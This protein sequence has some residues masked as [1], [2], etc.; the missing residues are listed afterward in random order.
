LESANQNI[1]FEVKKQVNADLNNRKDPSGDA[2][3]NLSEHQGKLERYQGALD[4]FIAEQKSFTEQQTTLQSQVDKK[5]KQWEAEN[6]RE[7]KF[8]DGNF[9]CP[10]CKRPL[11]EEGIEQEKEKMITDFKEDKQTSLASINREGKA[12]AEQRD[13]IKSQKVKLD[14]RIADG[15]KLIKEQVAKVKEMQSEVNKT[16]GQEVATENPETTLKNALDGHKV[17]QDNIKE[18]AKIKKSIPEVKPIDVSELKSKKEEVQKELNEVKALIAS[19]D[20]ITKADDRVAELKSQQ[21]KLAQEIATIEKQEYQAQQFTIAKVTA[22]EQR[23]NSMF[24]QVLFKMFDKQVNGQEV[25]TC[26]CTYKG[27]DWNDVNTAGKIK[28]GLDIIN[29]LCKHYGATAPVMIDGA[30]SITE[31]PTTDSQQIRLIVEKGTK[32]LI[33]R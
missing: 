22:V 24:D 21:K 5:G 15:A 31:I 10:T 3:D 4:K 2:L 28:A 1:E 17:Y 12:L 9:D 32:E 11:E 18:V 13:Q 26:I 20:Q 8:D 25:E 30:E 29:T 23:V 19:Q 14:S 6:A 33:V 16:V 27:V 7:L